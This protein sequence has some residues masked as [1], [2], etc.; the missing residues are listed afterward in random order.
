VIERRRCDPDRTWLIAWL[1]TA[2][3]GH[4]R[5]MKLIKEREEG[6]LRIAIGLRIGFFKKQE[7]N[8]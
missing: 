1:R 2:E 5:G 3:A 7:S 6:S 8:A 4:L